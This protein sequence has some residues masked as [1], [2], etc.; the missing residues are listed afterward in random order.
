MPPRPRRAAAS[1]VVSARDIAEILAD[2]ID[3]GADRPAAG[4]CRSCSR[5]AGQA[6]L[7]ADA[8]ARLRRV[9]HPAIGA[10]LLALGRGRVRVLAVR[11]LAVDPLPAERHE[12]RGDADH[13]RRDQDASSPTRSSI[14]GAVGSVRSSAIAC[15]DILVFPLMTRSASLRVVVANHDAS[16]SGWRIRPQQRSRRS[17]T[18]W[19]TSWVAAELRR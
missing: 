5:S 15:G 7:A 6:A 16:R 2:V 9:E 11:P 14:D 10:A 18:V 13:G 17:H 4:G 3:P 8:V 1:G 19:T 12:R